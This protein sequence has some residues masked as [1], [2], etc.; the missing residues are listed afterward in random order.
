MSQSHATLSVGD[1]TA[2]V[3]DNSAYGEHAA[4]YNGLW[5]LT[6]RAQPENIFVPKVAGMNLEHILNG[7][8]TKEKQVFFEPREAPMRL[9]VMD[10]RTAE[11]HQPPTPVTHVESW[12]QFKLVE[13]DAID[14]VFRA[15]PTVDVFP[16]GYLGFFWASYIR[17][18]ED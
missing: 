5:S 18:P 13:P 16:Q 7:N 11:L 10:D 14:L 17:A 2:V 9:T 3:G 1:L 15:T 6:H 8:T 4:G 12:T